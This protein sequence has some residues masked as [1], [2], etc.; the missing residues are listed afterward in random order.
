M[1]V[2]DTSKLSF[3]SNNYL[4]LPKK[5]GVY[6]NSRPLNRFFLQVGAFIVRLC[7]K[8]RLTW[9]NKCRFLWQQVS[10][11]LLSIQTSLQPV[12]VLAQCSCLWHSRGK[13]NI[14]DIIWACEVFGNNFIFSFPFLEPSIVQCQFCCTDGIS[15]NFCTDR[16]PTLHS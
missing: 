5:L 1:Y 8:I 9:N 10:K 2:W 11:V 14:A 12:V 15:E 7:L 13:W 4:S 3:V 6:R 16:L